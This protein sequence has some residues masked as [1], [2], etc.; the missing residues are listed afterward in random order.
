MLQA[1]SLR[2]RAR[3]QGL[4]SHIGAQ[5]HKVKKFVG[6]TFLEVSSGQWGFAPTDTDEEVSYDSFYVKACQDGDLWP[7]DEVTAA[8]CAVKFDPTFGT[9]GTKENKKGTS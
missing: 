5:E 3:G 9:P 4:V 6:R 1:K 7:A 8:I 2:F